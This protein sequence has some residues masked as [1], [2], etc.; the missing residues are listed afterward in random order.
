ME[1]RLVLKQLIVLFG[2]FEQF[3]AKPINILH[4]C[5]SFFYPLPG[6]YWSVSGTTFLPLLGCSVGG[7]PMAV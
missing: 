3:V 6:N 7:A 5:L 2:D 4:A 1:K